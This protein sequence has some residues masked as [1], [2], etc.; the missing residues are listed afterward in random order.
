MPSG[1][2]ASAAPSS[3]SSS[4]RSASS[5]RLSV[6]SSSSAAAGC[7]TTS[8]SWRRTRSGGRTGGIAWPRGYPRRGTTAVRSPTVQLEARAS[9]ARGRSRRRGSSRKPSTSASATTAR[10]GGRAELRQGD[11]R[12]AELR[13]G[14]RRA[15]RPGDEQVGLVEREPVEQ[16]RAVLEHRAVAP[17]LGRAAQLALPDPQVGALLARR[18]TPGP[19]GPSWRAIGGVDAEPGEAGDRARRR[20]SGRP[21]RR[22]PPAP[23]GRGIATA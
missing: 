10:V 2:S 9:T 22:P 17:D 6:A 1:S 13:A 20:A 3:S 23:S 21:R 8:R 15:S 5:V 18:S 14:H 12:G 19:A 7:R 4:R 16:D 11:G